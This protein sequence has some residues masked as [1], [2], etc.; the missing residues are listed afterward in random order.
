M[1][2]AYR[3]I[4]VGLPSTCIKVD[5]CL[6]ARTALLRPNKSQLDNVTARQCA[7]LGLINCV[8]IAL[9]TGKTF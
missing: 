2:R 5:G 9:A 3:D 1:P 8:N 4:R 6:L 7:N